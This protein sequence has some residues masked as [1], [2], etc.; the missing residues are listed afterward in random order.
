MPLTG[1]Q[2]VMLGMGVAR[3]MVRWALHCMSWCY[4]FAHEQMVGVVMTE[5]KHIIFVVLFDYRSAS[6]QSLWEIQV[7]VNFDCTTTSRVIGVVVVVVVV[8]VVL[9]VISSSKCLA[10]CWRETG[11]PQSST[12]PQKY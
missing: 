9:A 5:D 2:T 12:S 10:P 11:T 6:R 8:D 7:R 4:V 3:W 1:G